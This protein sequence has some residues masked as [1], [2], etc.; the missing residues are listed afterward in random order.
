MD[1]KEVTA[2]NFIPKKLLDIICILE[3]DEK[4]HSYKIIQNKNNFSLIAKS[5]AKNA[6]TTPLKN[7][8]SDQKQHVI[9]TINKFFPKTSCVNQ[10]ESVE[11]K[12]LHHVLLESLQVNI[13]I[14]GKILPMTGNQNNRS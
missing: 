12:N 9:R 14:R 11:R 5:G 8:A 6:E 13:R 7:N 3:R 4:Q 2:S 1:K 10:S